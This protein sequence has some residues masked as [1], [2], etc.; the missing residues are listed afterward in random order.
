VGFYIDLILFPQRLNSSFSLAVVYFL[1]DEVETAN[2]ETDTWLK[3]RDETETS[4]NIPTPR[5]ESSKFVC[6]GEIKKKKHGH[7]F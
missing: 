5:L 4:S 2:V 6:F 3:L 7:H 1:S